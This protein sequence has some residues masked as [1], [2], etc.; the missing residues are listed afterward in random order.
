[1]ITIGGQ[2]GWTTYSDQRVKQNIE[3]NV[4]GLSF[5]SLLQP[6]TYHY[7]I[8]REK[9]LLGIKNDNEEWNG[10]HD[11]ERIRFSGFIAQQVDAAA[12]SIGYNFSGVD[13]AGNVMGLRYAEFVVPLVKAVQEQQQQI[14]ALKLQNEKLLERLEKLEQK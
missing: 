14:D 3:H 13:K 9:E 6:V 7:N 1:M 8:A 2:V 10:K 4:P 12:N 11:I 5:I